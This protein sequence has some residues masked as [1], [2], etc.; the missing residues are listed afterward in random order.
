[1]QSNASSPANLGPW[2]QIND[3]VGQIHRMGPG[4]E[5]IVGRAGDFVVGAEDLDLHRQ[6]FQLWYSGQ[7]WMLANV[8]RHIQLYISQRHVRSYSR[9]EVGPRGLAPIPPGP[10]AITFTTPDCVYEIHIDVQNNDMIRRTPRPLDEEG[11]RTRTRHVPNDE[12]ELL[13]RQLASYLRAPGATDANIPAIREVAQALG[14]TEKKTNQKIDRLI[15]SLKEDGEAVYKPYKNC[16]AH[17]AVQRY[18]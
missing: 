10:T 16:L 8:G 12:Q 18:R 6:L 7:G 13:L 3:L 17:Y 5:L 11:D 9:I 2:L 15:E 14:W 4:D 1:M